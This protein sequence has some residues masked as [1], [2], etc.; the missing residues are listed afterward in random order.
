MTEEIRKK[1]QDIKTL[2]EDRLSAKTAEG[3]I[4]EVVFAELLA[5]PIKDKK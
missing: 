1:I 4:L 3:N 2:C 5:M